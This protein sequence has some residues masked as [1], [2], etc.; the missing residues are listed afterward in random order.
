MPRILKAAVKLLETLYILSIKRL[1]SHSSCAGLIVSLLLA[2]VGSLL[3]ARYVF[4]A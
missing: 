2:A 3:P 1:L 4:S